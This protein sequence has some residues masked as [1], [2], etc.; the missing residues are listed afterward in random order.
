MLGLALG[1]A[2]AIGNELRRN[3][4]LGEWELP[5]GTVVMGV[6]PKIQVGANAGAP[7]WR[8]G[9]WAAVLCSAVAAA[10]YY[11]WLQRF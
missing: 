2:V 1:L 7:R 3:V 10:G 11:V 9:V 5:P 4:L 6:L 8:G